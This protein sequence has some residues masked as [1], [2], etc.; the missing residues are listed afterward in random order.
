MTGFTTQYRE[1]TAII[2]IDNP[3]ANTW[4]EA[5][6]SAL[7][8]LVLQLN[9][10]PNI[11]SLVITGQGEKFFSA[12]A[13]LKMFASGEKSIAQRASDVFGRSFTALSQ[14]NGVSIAAVNGYAMGGG[15]EAAMACDFRVVEEQGLMALPEAKV[16]L[17]PCG[18]GTQ[19]LTRLVGESWA[20]KMILLF[21]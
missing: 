14:F 10:D 1:H 17:L 6:L 5:S 12:G 3:P 4:T 20:K 7:E 18:L 16:G 13:D 2:T 8:E 21:S 11:R 15:L 19:T 9:D